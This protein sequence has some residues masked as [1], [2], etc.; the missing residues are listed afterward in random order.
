MYGLSLYKL[1]A[2]L[3]TEINEVGFVHRLI[4]PR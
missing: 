4:F 2:M 3:K 1:L